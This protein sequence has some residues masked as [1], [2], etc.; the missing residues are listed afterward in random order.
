MPASLALEPASLA[1]EPFS[2]PLLCQ[3][4]RHS[5]APLAWRPRESPV[6]PLLMLVSGFPLTHFLLPSTF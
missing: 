1:L 5:V 3:P 2:A 4:L 6:F